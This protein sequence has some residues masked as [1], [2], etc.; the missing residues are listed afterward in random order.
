MRYVIVPITD[1]TPAPENARINVAGT[2]CILDTDTDS[3]YTMSHEE[4]LAL[5]ETDEWRVPD[6]IQ[7]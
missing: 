1:I 6:V 5:M 7:E 3:P 2:A 4:S